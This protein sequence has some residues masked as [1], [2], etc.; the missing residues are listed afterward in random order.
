MSRGIT[1]TVAIISVCAFLFAVDS[2][3]TIAAKDMQVLSRSL[4]FVKGTRANGSKVGIVYDPSSPDSTA[5]AQAAMAQLGSSVKAGDR[6]LTPVLLK[7][8]EIGQATDMAAYFLTSG[9][10][11]AATAVAEASKANGLPC[12]TTDVAQVQKGNCLISINTDK[13]V[14]ILINKTVL[15]ANGIVIDEAFRMLIKEI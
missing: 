13:K 11:S 14:E 5:D 8:G 4:G 2:S 9:V 15:E 6:S 3:G 12:I 7:I 1:V 10:G